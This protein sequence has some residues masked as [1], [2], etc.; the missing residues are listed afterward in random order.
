MAIEARTKTTGIIEVF[1]GTKDGKKAYLNPSTGAT[2]LNPKKV[3]NIEVLD[4]RALEPQ[5]TVKDIGHEI[6]KSPTTLTVEQLLNDTTPEGKS[7]IKENYWP[8]AAS[9]VQQQSGAAHVEPWHF[10]VRKQTV[11]YHPDEIFFMRTGVSQPAST[12]HIDNNHDT[13]FDHMKRELGEEK[14][15]SMVEKYK[16]WAIFNVWRPIGIPVQRWPLLFV[17][18]SHVPGSMQYDQDTE[19]IFR[20]DN[21]EY[22][23]SHD[24]F[25]KYHPEYQ[26]RYASN[27][28]PEEALIF[29]DYDSRKDKIRGTPHGGFQDDATAKD[30]PARNSIE[31]RLFAFFDDE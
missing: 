5:P 17:D 21:P 1:D 30:A 12:L 27:L 26:Y 3:H 8:E 16:R 25:L 19:R 2:N 22:Y 23:K 14:A 11:G 28:T 10:S 15:K 31:V 6:V 24:N 20:V 13:A 7:F 18:Y 4:I 9:L 29:K